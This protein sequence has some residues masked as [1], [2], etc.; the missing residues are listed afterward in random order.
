MSLQRQQRKR[1]K[2]LRKWVYIVIS[3]L[4]LGI[5]GY[6]T[7]IALSVK[8]TADKVHVDLSRKKSDKRTEEVSLQ[9]L[10]PITLLLMGVDERE[11]DKGR[12][13]TMILVTLNPKKNSMQMFNLPRDTRMEL[14]GRGTQD[15]INHAYAYGGPEMSIESVENFF[16][17]PIDYFISVNMEALSEVVDALGGITVNNPISW[18]ETG[19]YYEKA[20]FVYEK[21]EINLDGPQ[22]LGFVRMRY[23]DPRG[24]FGRQEREKLVLN[25]IIE[26]GASLS[27]VTKI[28]SLLDVI[29]NNVQTNMTLDDMINLQANYAGTRSNQET[30]EIKGSGDTID[31]VWYYIVPEEERLAVESRIKEFL[32][33]N[34]G[35]S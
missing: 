26:K 18:V 17:I 32:E 11:G 29:G 35:N 31:G 19:G 28:Q 12:S 30:F 15:K 33:I 5:I 34:N 7:H 22:T 13:D 9:E 6:G 3:V 20:G 4:L 21:G 23:Q 10:N 2:K 24:D 14:V 16:D 8:S 1:K 27:S 25:A